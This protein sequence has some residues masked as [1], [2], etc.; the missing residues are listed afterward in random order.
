MAKY[1]APTQNYWS[2]TLNGAINDSVDQITLNSTSN[3]QAPGFLVIDREDGNGT[4][5][6]NSREVISFTGISGN[7]ITG[8][9]RAADNSTARSHSDGALVESIMTVGVW[10]DLQTNLLTANASITIAH[11]A[12]LRASMASINTVRA[13]NLYASAATIGAVNTGSLTGVNLLSLANLAVTSSASIKTMFITTHIN[14]SGASVEG[15]TTSGTRPAF[16]A[17]KNGSAQ[18]GGFGTSA[19]QITFGTELF[20]TNNNFASSAFTP[21]VAGK[22][23]LHANI[24]S[25]GGPTDQKLIIAMIYK[26]G[27][28]AARNDNSQSGTQGFSV[29]VSAIL[30]A[31]GSTDTFTVYALTDNASAV[32]VSGTATL[33]FF[34]GCKID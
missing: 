14:A 19:T 34:D 25:T 10:N 29:A 6:P 20:D 31:N 3:L 4:A 24:S 33:T 11:I 16:S 9:T 1:L 2:T 23:L 12:Q 5:T 15:F 21:T 8:V 17:N 18:T 28:V 22:Y 26:N 32:D 13:Q 7:N 30:D 27:S